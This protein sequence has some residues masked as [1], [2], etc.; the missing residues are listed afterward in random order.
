[1]RHALCHLVLEVS[2]VQCS[3]AKVAHAQ[4]SGVMRRPPYHVTHTVVTPL[5]CRAIIIRITSLSQLLCLQRFRER[6]NLPLSMRKIALVNSVD[7]IKHSV[8]IEMLQ[9]NVSRPMMRAGRGKNL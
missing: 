7:L 8:W 6:V 4:D 2:E 1:M 9:I 5:H 3:C